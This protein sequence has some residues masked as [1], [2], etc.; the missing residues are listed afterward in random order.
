MADQF[1]KRKSLGEMNQ[2]EWESLCDGCGLCCMHKVEDED[3]GDLFYTNLACRL[4]DTSTCRCTDYKNRSKLV[5][6]CLRLTPNTTDAFEW[7][8][9]TCAYRLL[10]FGEELRDWHP[11]ISGD[12]ESVHEAGISVRGKVVSENDTDEWTVLWKVDEPD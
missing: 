12:P 6:D 10:A 1:W 4:L 11:L 7:L 8:P 5:A 3:T 2:V 9:A